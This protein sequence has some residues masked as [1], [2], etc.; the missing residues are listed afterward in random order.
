MLSD[1]VVEMSVGCM[2]LT[3]GLGLGFSQTL[4]EVHNHFSFT[5][6]ASELGLLGATAVLLAFLVF[7]YRGTKIAILAYDPASKLL[8]GGLSAGLALQTI[9]IVGGVTKA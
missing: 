1:R 3:H 9:I 6:I 2:L 7:V 4:P 5:A 8:A